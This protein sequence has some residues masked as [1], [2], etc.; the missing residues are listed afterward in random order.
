MEGKIVPSVHSWDNNA[1]QLEAAQFFEQRGQWTGFNGTVPLLSN[2]REKEKLSGLLLKRG[3]LM[4][5]IIKHGDGYQ[6]KIR[7]KGFTPVSKTFPS[8][9]LANDWGINTESEMLRGQYICRD[10]A[11]NTTLREAL[12][13]YATEITPEKPGAYTE[14]YRI[15]FLQSQSFADRSLSS[16]R[17][18]DFIKYRS[19]RRQSLR[20]NLSK[21]DK[22]TAEVARRG[23]DL[24]S[25]PPKFFV[26]DCTV[27]KELRLI[28]HLFNIAKN[29][30]GMFM[31]K[32]QSSPLNCHQKANREV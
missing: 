21:G 11:E 1:S 28:S 31:W 8:R 7:R 23:K 17:P 32:T 16:L 25:L 4:A 9:K 24:S 27:R 29:R 26:S 22:K 13:R 20:L 12:E 15:R 18:A 30:G 5:T 3:W 19:E 14:L 2:P 10:S 6:V